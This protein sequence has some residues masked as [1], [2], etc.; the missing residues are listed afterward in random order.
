[1]LKV[2][3]LFT[4]IGGL[5]LGVEAA[6]GQCHIAWQVE[7]NDHCRGILR[8]HWPNARQYG[9]I[10]NFP[11]NAEQVDLICG[12][13]PCQPHSQAGK[14]KGM[15]DERWLWP[16]YRS[17]IAMQLPCIVFIE[18]VPGLRTS[19]LSTVLADLAQLGYDAAW[20]CFSANEVGAPH[21]RQRLFVFAYNNAVNGAA[22]KLGHIAFWTK[23]KLRAKR[24]ECLKLWDVPSPEACAGYD[25]ATWGLDVQAI[26][27][28]VVWQQAELAF[29]ELANV[30]LNRR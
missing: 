9:D 13:F 14:R 23:P 20:D 4:G 22:E 10:R 15:Q 6:L 27:N 28:A 3:S 1:M 7:I 29:L 24:T 18:N 19:G 26:G 11:A 2:G 5:D 12:G 16:E 30:A 8:Q 17:V 21:R 25:G